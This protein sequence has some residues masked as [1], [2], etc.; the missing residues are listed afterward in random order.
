MS[1]LQ[2][3]DAKYKGCPRNPWQAAFLNYIKFETDQ[4]KSMKK[5][6]AW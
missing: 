1:Q 2:F 5:N 3:K 6:K 4:R